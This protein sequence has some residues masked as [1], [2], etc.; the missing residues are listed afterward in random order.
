MSDLLDEVDQARQSGVDL[1]GKPL[2]ASAPEGSARCPSC[3]ATIAENAVLCV[4]CGYNLKSG[5]KLSGAKL[6]KPKT[7]RK[8]TASSGGPSFLTLLRGT[9]F[10]LIGAM[11]GAF[12][13]VVVALFFGLSIGWIAWGLGALAGVGMSL[14]HEDDDGTV[15]GIIAGVCALFGLLAAKGVIFGIVMLPLLMTDFVESGAVWEVDENSDMEFVRAGL[16]NHLMTEQLGGVDAIEEMDDETYVQLSEE[17]LQQAE[18]RVA[19]MSDEEVVV[20]FNEQQQRVLSD[21]REMEDEYKKEAG[22]GDAPG[23]FATMFGPI[24]GIFILLALATAFKIG[25][26]SPTD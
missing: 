25:S 23:F 21:L 4:A 5:T 10:S 11:L 22:I 26:G 7:M 1:T 14:G 3:K 12:V 8:K 9:I 6:S 24:D 15:A 20:A 17:A 2:Q 18:D 16:A 19:A 13:W